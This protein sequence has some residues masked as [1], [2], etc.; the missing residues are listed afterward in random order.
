MADN[1]SITPGVGVDV[2]TDEVGGKHYQRI[3]VSHGADGEAT[4]TSADAPLPTLARAEVNDAPQVFIPGEIQTLSLTPEGR[5]RVS[6]AEP[7]IGDAPFSNA[8]RA[9]WGDLRPWDNG[10]NQPYF[11]G[12]P[13]AAW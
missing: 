3:K 7:R 8:M 13:W 10:E 9:M 2:A 6:S 11:D 5:L 1:I 4:D 12:S